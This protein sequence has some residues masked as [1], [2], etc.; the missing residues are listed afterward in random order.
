MKTTDLFAE[1]IVIGVGTLAAIVLLLL[2]IAPELAANIHFGSPMALLPALAV[3][4]VLGIIA[5]RAAD[6]MLQR[7]ANKRRKITDPISSV[8]WRLKRDRVFSDHPGV[9]ED[10]VYARSRLRVVRGWFLNA[11]LLAITSIFYFLHQPRTLHSP[12]SA[13]FAGVGFGVLALACFLVWN[14]LDKAEVAAIVH[15]HAPDSSAQDG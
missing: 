9:V 8:Q 14:H 11:I 1:I 4:Y 2:S 3:A 6:R 13:A 15:R 10:G 12:N 7:V 5:D